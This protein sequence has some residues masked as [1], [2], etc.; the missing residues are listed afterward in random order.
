MPFEVP[1]PTLGVFP[2]ERLRLGGQGFETRLLS[3]RERLRGFADRSCLRVYCPFR[4][5]IIVGLGLAGLDLG[6]LFRVAIIGAIGLN[7]LYVVVGNVVALGR[8]VL[9]LEPRER[10]R[11]R[12]KIVL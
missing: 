11:G 10:R 2:E 5:S 7:F 4:F 8:R 6:Y 9:G 1:F 3:V 12:A